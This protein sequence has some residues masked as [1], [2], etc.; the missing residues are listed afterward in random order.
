MTSLFLADACAIIV[1]LLEPVGSMG[2]AGT[3]AMNGDVL[4]SPIT[5]WEIS[6]KTALGKLPAFP[7]RTCSLAR[8]LAERG[9]RIHPLTWADAERANVLPP[10][11]KDPM[12]RMLI[13]QALNTD[14][15]IVTIDRLFEGYGVRTVW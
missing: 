11:H 8:Y 12:D 1:F 4:V 5:V 7:G 14:L 9:F 15:T 2:P 6:R 13:A 10:I 3:A